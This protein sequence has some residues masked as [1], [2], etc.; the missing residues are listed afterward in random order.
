MIIL[1]ICSTLLTFNKI[2]RYLDL[3]AKLNY[4]PPF[5]LKD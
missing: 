1:H 5:E 2:Y 4:L 3:E